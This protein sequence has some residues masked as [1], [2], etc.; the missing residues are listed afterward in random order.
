MKN[1]INRLRERIRRYRLH[2]WLLDGMESHVGPRILYAGHLLNLNY[3]AHIAHGDNCRVEKLGKVWIQ[4]I[5]RLARS[6]PAV[7]IIVIETDEN[8]YARHAGRQ[9][10]YIPC[11]IDGMIEFSRFNA[12]LPHS[13][14]IK[15]DLRKTKKQNYHYEISKETDKFDLFYH[16]MYRPYILK[17]HGNRAALM[18]Y[19]A[20][21]K[22][23]SITKLLLIKQGDEYVAGENLLFEEGR[24]RAWSLG[25]KDGDY[26]HVKD[27]VLGALYYYKIQ[28]LSG[29]G[30][31]SYHSGACRSFLKD[32]VLQYKKKWG[33]CLTQAR[34]GGF[35]LQIPARS[36]GAAVFLKDNPFI[37]LDNGK[38]CGTIFSDGVPIE[39]QITSIRKLYAIPG[40]AGMEVAHPDNPA[41]RH[42]FP[43]T[44]L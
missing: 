34:P 2:A 29:L 24:V 27:G 8:Y 36:E 17:A 6:V 12:L 10:F 21:M 19:D 5:G 42:M 38:L 25:V 20:M 41:A 35:W 7:D 9:D 31:N 3:I 32:G 30:Y 13:E 40:L 33:L 37:H 23:A 14:N 11:W 1:P 28:Y 15:S 43:I 44:G 26:K 4:S 39:E 16:T 22:K 18:S